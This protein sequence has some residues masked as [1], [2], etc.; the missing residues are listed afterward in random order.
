MKWLSALQHQHSEGSVHPVSSDQAK[1]EGQ[2]MT[3][4]EQRWSRIQNQNW[5]P[6]MTNDHNRVYPSAENRTKH[7]QCDGKKKKKKSGM[8]DVNKM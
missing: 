1:K 7:A 6:Q 3:K 4:A 8:Q 2:Y 5:E